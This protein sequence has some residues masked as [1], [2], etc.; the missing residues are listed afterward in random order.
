MINFILMGNIK[1]GPAGLGAVKEAISNLETYKSFGLEACEI[2]FTYGVYIKNKED[3]EE[4]GKAAE[5]LGIELSIHAPYWVNLNSED[6][7]KIEK[8]KQRILECL[9]VGTWLKA[10]RVVFH[11]GYYGKI[12]DTKVPFMNPPVKFGVTPD[13]KIE[14]YENIK[15]EILEIMKEAKEKHYTPKLAPET[16]GKIN[17]FGSVEEIASLVKQTGCEF[18]IDFAHILAR[19]K[20]IEYDLIEKSFP[21]RKW[22]VHFSGIEYGEKG[23]KRHKRT[24]ESE[25]RNLL[26]NLSK[27]R[28]IIIINESPEPVRDSILGL[29]IY[30]RNT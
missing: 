21:Q 25:L 3:A 2:A 18:C 30:T 16:T 1:F 15:N 6:R 12:K 14:T 9:K 7:E 20:K 27:D 4:I 10:Y 13:S 24:D 5:K 19:E 26:K 29:G 23:E 28:K 11:P 8:S 22:H 17:V